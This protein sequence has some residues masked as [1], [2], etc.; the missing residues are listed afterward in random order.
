MKGNNIPFSLS[1]KYLTL[2]PTWFRWKDLLWIATTR[3]GKTLYIPHGSDERKSLCKTLW[4]ST[5]LYPTW[6][7]WKQAY[8]VTLFRPS[9]PL[10]PTWF[11][12]KGI[13]LCSGSLSSPPLYP[14]W[15]RWKIST[16][17]YFLKS[18]FPLYPTWFRW[19][20]EF[21]KRWLTACK[22]YIPHG[23]DERHL[24]TSIKTSCQSFISHMVQM[25]VLITISVIHFT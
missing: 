1:G 15:F 6:F 3:Q 14:T 23:S 11:R 7:R 22:L 19:K 17:R 20:D 12:W 5:T 9:R 25:K 10:Y 24:I 18:F 13:L 16:K 21:T 2:Y 4:V 8:Q